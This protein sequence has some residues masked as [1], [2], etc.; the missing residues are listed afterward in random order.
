MKLSELRL[1]RLEG[2]LQAHIME[3]LQL[4]TEAQEASRAENPKM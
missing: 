4:L 2:E 3:K 1:E